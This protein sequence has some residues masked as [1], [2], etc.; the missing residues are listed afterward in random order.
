MLHAGSAGSVLQLLRWKRT[1]EAALQSLMLLMRQ[2]VAMGGPICNTLEEHLL[3]FRLSEHLT[4]L[5]SDG[6]SSS[7]QMCFGS[8]PA[9]GVRRLRVGLR[10]SC[11]CGRVVQV[12]RWH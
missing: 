10:K 9:C 4:A 8:A 1:Q 12:P 6:Q 7:L 11:L 2:S 5:A 3:P